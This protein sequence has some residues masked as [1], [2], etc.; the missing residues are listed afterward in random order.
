MG[1]LI[2]ASRDR[3]FSQSPKNESP[4]NEDFQ[5]FTSSSPLRYGR[6]INYPVNSQS[7]NILTKS[8]N[9]IQR[10][11]PKWIFFE[12]QSFALFQ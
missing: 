2:N 8:E 6:D 3:H 10:N 9:S 4:E 7:F 12:F 1:V 11:I 5:D